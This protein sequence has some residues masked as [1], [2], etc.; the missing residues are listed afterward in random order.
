MKNRHREGMMEENKKI[1]L[2]FFICSLLLLGLLSLLYY[3]LYLKVELKIVILISVLLSIVTCYTSYY[4]YVKMLEMFPRDL[5]YFNNVNIQKGEKIS[6]RYIDIAKF[7]VPT[8]HSFLVMCITVAALIFSLYS[9][10]MKVYIGDSQIIPLAISLIFLVTGLIIAILIINIK[11]FINYNKL[12][13]IIISKEKNTVEGCAQGDVKAVDQSHNS[14]IGSYDNLKTIVNDAIKN[15]EISIIETIEDE[16]QLRY[17][18]KYAE[19]LISWDGLRFSYYSFLIGAM[20]I[21]VALFAIG[22]SIYLFG[23]ST[24][25]KIVYLILGVIIMGSGVWEILKTIKTRKQFDKMLEENKFIHDLILK[26][27]EKL[28]NRT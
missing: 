14:P 19:S 2:K 8:L 23:E 28:L 4:A 21:G 7:H 24:V 17:L 10:Y 6:E 5:F 27:E 3:L 16:K 15:Q 12:M 26:I 18:Q 25:P 1:D 20:G 9:L 11:W 13:N 22:I